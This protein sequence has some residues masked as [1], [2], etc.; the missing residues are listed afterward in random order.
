MLGVRAIALAVADLAAN[1]PASQTREAG[2]NDEAATAA[3]GHLTVLVNNVP[4]SRRAP[5][6]HSW[7]DRDAHH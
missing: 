6:Q 2:G 5:V 1:R 3:F 4:R 7:L